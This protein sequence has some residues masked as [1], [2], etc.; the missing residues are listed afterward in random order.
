MSLDD[1]ATAMR[2]PGLTLERFLHPLQAFVILPLFAFF[3]AGVRLGDRGLA[4]LT[5]P[6]T[7]G[8]LVGLVAGK[9]V[10]V[11]GLSWVAVRAGYAGL[12]EG[13]TWPQI[14]GVALLGGVG[15]TM[16]LFVAELAF[17]PGARL[18][19]AK[20]GILIASL[21]AGISG[22]LLLRVVLP[23]STRSG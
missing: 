6:I 4:V 1:A 3:N 2:P 8:V 5:E 19:A 18:D 11:F 17:G 9:L 14:A 21:A 15:F 16:S 12:P 13:V 10:G 22:Y 7:L 20:V 23:R